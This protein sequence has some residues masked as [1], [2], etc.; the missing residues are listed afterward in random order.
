MYFD[1]VQESGQFFGSLS[2]TN[3]L[4]NETLSGG[5]GRTSLKPGHLTRHLRVAGS[6]KQ[7]PE[8][9][10][11]TG[12]RIQHP[13]LTNLDHVSIALPLALPPLRFLILSF[14]VD[15]EFLLFHEQGSG[16]D[17]ILSVVYHGHTRRPGRFRDRKN[18]GNR[19]P[20][21]GSIL[22]HVSSG[23]GSGVSD[24]V[25]RGEAADRGPRQSRLPGVGSWD[26]ERRY[27]GCHFAEALIEFGK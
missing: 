2:D 5:C 14:L 19:R 22:G 9:G 23:R 3:D 21:W 6:G 12:Q 10:E 11:P 7:E 13:S 1:T 16:V 8:L 25:G 17:Q 27:R 26:L 15:D 18:A 24:V 20:G 4:N